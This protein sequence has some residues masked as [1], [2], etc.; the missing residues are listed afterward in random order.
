MAA[1]EDKGVCKEPRISEWC[2]GVVD[3]VDVVDVRGVQWGQRE[4]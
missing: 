3:V 4:R 1:G 2:F